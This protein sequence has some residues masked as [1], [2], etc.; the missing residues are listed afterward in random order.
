[1]IRDHRV[2]VGF[3]G[4]SEERADTIVSSG[5]FIPS[6]NDY[7]WLG[8]GIYFWEYAPLR[9]W[10]WAKQKYR[11]RAAVVRASIELGAC[12]DLTDLRYTS[13]LQIVIRDATRGLPAQ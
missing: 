9:A 2:V 11:D 6:K 1:M 8:H 13:A 12:L 4:T 3:H 7:D 5:Q 10:Q